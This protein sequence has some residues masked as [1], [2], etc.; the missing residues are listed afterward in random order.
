MISPV[1]WAGVPGVG[2]VLD[3]P[4]QVIPNPFDKP[5]RALG[6]MDPL[7]VAAKPPQNGYHQDGGRRNPESLDGIAPQC[8]QWQNPLERLGQR[9]RLGSQDGVHGDLDDL[10]HQSVK[11]HA[12]T[13]AEQGDGKVAQAAPQIAENQAGLLPPGQFEWC[14]HV[15][16]SLLWCDSMKKS[17]PPTRGALSSH[18]SDWA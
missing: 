8:V 7:A 9:H 5:L 13:G 12:E 14:F 2:Q 11:H 1:E 15:I 10:R 3:V 17:A 16:D 6:K 4:V 18:V